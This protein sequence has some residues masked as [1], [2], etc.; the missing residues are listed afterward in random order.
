MCSWSRAAQVPDR[1]SDPQILDSFRF[2]GFPQQRSLSGGKQRR[3]SASSEEAPAAQLPRPGGVGCCVEKTAALSDL[4]TCTTSGICDSVLDSSVALPDALA[5]SRGSPVQ[6]VWTPRI[7]SPGLARVRDIVH[8]VSLYNI[9][10]D[11]LPPRARLGPPRPSSASGGPPAAARCGGVTNPTSVHRDAI[12]RSEVQ[13]G[14]W[15]A[16]PGLSPGPLNGR[17]RCRPHEVLFTPVQPFVQQERAVCGWQQTQMTT[18][19]SLV[20]QRQH[21]ARRRLIEV[22]PATQPTASG[23]YAE[24]KQPVIKGVLLS[25]A[26]CQRDAGASVRGIVTIFH[27]STWRQCV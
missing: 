18:G 12:G 14:V 11:T 22:E 1:I 9:Y 10:T 6:A 13:L 3:N 20:A 23:E 5:L 7:A 25:V 8:M 21:C 4:K 24:R 2:P 27:R 17:L 26:D 16:R 15:I 19:C